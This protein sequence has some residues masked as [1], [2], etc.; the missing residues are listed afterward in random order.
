MLLDWFTVGAQIVNFVILVWLMKHFL[1]QPILTAIDA[2]EKKIAAE[3]AR[4]DEISQAAT[5]AKKEFDGK[6]AEFDQQRKQLMTDAITAANDEGKRLEEEAR[7]RADTF[8]QKQQAT[9]HDKLQEQLTSLRT[10]TQKELFAISKDALRDLADTDI[11]AHMVKTFSKQLHAMPD[12]Q[13]QTL[14]KAINAGELTISS[15]HT[16]STEQQS[17]LRSDVQQCLDIKTDILFN[18]KPG[19]ISGIE[20]K[21]GGMKLGWNIADYIDSLAKTVSDQIQLNAPNKEEHADKR[22]TKKTTK[23]AVASTKSTSTSAVKKNEPTE[24]EQT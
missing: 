19:L 13:K 1:Y 12:E 22:P 16:L 15:S 10:T 3:L 17:L 6:N 7:R 20:L 14:Q 9:V 2:R 4:A 11:E 18:E 8:E 5:D 24:S 21:A 23:K